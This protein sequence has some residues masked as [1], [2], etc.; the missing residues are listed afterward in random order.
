MAKKTIHTI[1]QL[2]DK[3]SQPI[4]NSTKNTKKFKREVKK[5]K[6]SIKRFKNGAVSDFKSVAKGAIG[7]A[8]AY[9]GF[10]ALK[11]GMTDCV[12]K[13]KEQIEV[14]TKLAAVFKATGKASKKQIK[15]LI[16]QADTLEGVGVV[17]ADVS[18]AFQ[19]QLATYNLTADS[20]SS[21]SAGAGDLIAQM[22]GLNSAQG[23]GVN[24]GNMFGKV[25]NGQLG[26]LS[27]AGIT[28]SE[29]QGKM[30][31]YGTEQE[32]VATLVKVLE[33][34]VGGVNKELANT[35]DG[36]ILAMKNNWD[37]YKETLGRIILP[38]QAKFAQ[39][40]NVQIPYIEA[41]MVNLVNSIK[42]NIRKLVPILQNVFKWI[43]NAFKSK[44]M[45]LFKIF[46]KIVLK[47]M[48][49]LL[50]K[51]IEIVK[52]IYKNW[53]KFEPLVY[54]IVGAIAAYNAVMLV[55]KARTL[56]L[57]GAQLALNFAMNANPWGL[58]YV[59]IAA[60][61]A[62]GVVLYKNWD[63]IKLKT[64]ELWKSFKIF[65][66][67]VRKR[68]PLLG[69]VIEIVVKKMKSVFDGLK[70][71][72]RGITEFISGVFAG[73]WKRAWEGLKTIFSGVFNIFK[74][75]IKT[76]ND[77]VIRLMNLMIRKINGVKFKIFE[78]WESFKIFI[79]KI[80]KRFP[81]LG[82]IIETNIEKWKGIF[83]GARIIFSGI[84]EFISGVFTGDWKRA[85]EGVKTIFS[86]V[87]N[88]LESIAKAPIN[89]VIGLMN[90]MIEK[91]NGVKFK[92]PEWLGDKLGGKS[93]G[94]TVPKIPKLATGSSY[95]TKGKYEIND[96]AY[97]GEIVDLPNGSKVIPA[98]KTDKML[99][100]QSINVYV[101]I[102]GN[103]IGNDEYA[104]EMGNRIVKKVKLALVNM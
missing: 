79:E 68:F 41:H 39:W 34:N 15:Q 19:Q 37:G 88:T 59:A 36:K 72:L 42:S 96:G 29:A 81:L 92:L 82:I 78:L 26:A 35:D 69:V 18:I 7:L 11:D 67:K 90:I 56:A 70:I 31:K 89:G 2:K 54:G 64:Y 75:I 58:I 9:L 61:I 3:F 27:R 87:F 53:S 83:D 5:T 86:G 80:K 48:K 8:G 25:L 71:I 57:K 102:E 1:L 65:I 55:T 49:K 66:D 63:K 10:K 77:G 40:F 99:S 51:I 60:I 50:K 76:L 44:Q 43:K 104:D 32:K 73:D 74:V 100:N 13:A 38:M 30:L 103:V 62:I 101:N 95:T 93:I 46:I 98:D 12:E 4:S 33:Q 94:F 45:E 85:W 14:E 52:F 22:K 28:F 21:L 24:V 20:V 84:T 97:G 91:V 23:D 16:N 17:G 47:E 6:N